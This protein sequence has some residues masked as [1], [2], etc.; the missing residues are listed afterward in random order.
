VTVPNRDDVVVAPDLDAGTQLT[1]TYEQ[2]VEALHTNL[3]S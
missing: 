1:N 3:N 2:E